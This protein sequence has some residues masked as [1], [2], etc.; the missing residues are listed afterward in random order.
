[1]LQVTFRN[2][3]PSED[4]IAAAN[5]V[6]LEARGRWQSGS[7]RM[8]CHVIV[9][10]N[11]PP[12]QGWVHVQVELRHPEGNTARVRAEGADARLA[13]RSSMRAAAQANLEPKCVRQPAHATDALN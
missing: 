13:V 3:L 9:S 2:L 12:A 6:Y 4:L 11:S 5:D 8:R 10:A 1:M 7:H